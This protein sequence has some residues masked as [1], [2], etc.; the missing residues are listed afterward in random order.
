MQI[1]GVITY[2]Q[3]GRAKA[4]GKLGILFLIPFL[5]M[6]MI[7]STQ[8]GAL[9]EYQVKA[10]FLYNFTQFVE[11]PANA[12]P[13]PNTPL[14]IG[15]LGQDP[16][17]QYLDE[18]VKGEKVNEH[19]LIVKRFRTID[20]IRQCHILFINVSEK[21]ELAAIFENLRSQNILTVGDAANF[22]KQGG[23]VRFFNEKNKT[24]IR[25]NLEAAKNADLTISSKLLRLAE[26][27][28]PSDN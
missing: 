23:I 9:P 6:N 18:T 21:N 15:I 11:W 25:I 4:F 28:N 16:F 1:L 3:R 13:E 24:R 22:S 26:V 5:T 8:Q 17:G 20:E 2:L 12:F 14:V 19:P 27:V 7:A 10:V